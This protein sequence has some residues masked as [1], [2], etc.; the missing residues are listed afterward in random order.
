MKEQLLAEWDE[1][2]KTT[3]GGTAMEQIKKQLDILNQLQRIDP[4]LE[5]DGLPIAQQISSRQE[6]LTVINND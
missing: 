1:V 5:I 4:L 6:Q 2:K 3:W